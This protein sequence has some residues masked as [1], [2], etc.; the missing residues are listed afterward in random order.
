MHSPINRVQDNGEVWCGMYIL[1][2]ML[3]WP[4]MCWVVYKNRPY[5]FI[6][7]EELVEVL[8]DSIG[9]QMSHVQTLHQAHM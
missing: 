9:W 5:T 7:Y 3:L 6:D 1:A 8:N 4:L 2:Q